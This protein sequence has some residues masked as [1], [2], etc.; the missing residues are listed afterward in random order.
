MRSS[1]TATAFWVLAVIIVSTPALSDQKTYGT[2]FAIGNGTFIVTANHVVEGCTSIDIP[3]FGSATIVRSEPKS[4]LAIIKPNRPLVRGLPF[5][6]GHPVKLGEE[7]VVIGYPLRGLLS[8]S[9]IVTTG[10]VSSLAGI[11]NDPTQ[12][13]I[14]AP[15]QP[16]N[17]GGPVLDRSGNLV[18]V[19]VS[20]LNAVKAA[21]V[22]GDIPQNV[23]FAIQSSIATS[24]L[25][26][27]SIDYKVGTFEN[28][29]PISE[30]VGNTLPAVVGIECLTAIQL[31]APAVQTRMPPG[32]TVLRP[33][34]ESPAPAAQTRVARIQ[35][36]IGELRS[37]LSAVRS[38]PAYSTLLPHLRDY[39]YD[40]GY[41]MAQL[42]D[43]RTPSAADA[44]VLRAYMDESTHCKDKW[45]AG[46]DQILPESA[47]IRKQLLVDTQAILWQLLTRQLTWGAAA[48]REQ[49]LLD[50][51]NGR[52]FP[53]A[54]VW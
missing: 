51:P 53:K 31:P 2:G 45:L 13:Q 38:K 18:G 39:S 14:S 41:T 49:Q 54:M 22:T 26:S 42:A 17:S 33:G 9:P 27:Y 29:K 52:N 25:D 7:V 44:Q 37:C 47:P 21:V 4:D 46:I 12:M 15:V 19:V 43:D 1:R 24:L 3:D 8:S 16:G 11:R 30:I 36:V 20:K 48:Q 28:E 50:S 10:I 23:N 35:A 5:R 6:S 40:S 32:V 34:T